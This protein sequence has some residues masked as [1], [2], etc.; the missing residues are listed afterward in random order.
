ML[1]LLTSY[2]SSKAWEPTRILETVLHTKSRGSLELRLGVLIVA[3]FV[4][5]SAVGLL[6]TQRQCRLVAD[7]EEDISSHMFRGYMNVP[8]LDHI[9]KNS[10]QLIRNTYTMPI[11]IANLA[12]LPL[13]Q[14]TQSIFIVTFLLIVILL[15]SPLVVGISVLYFGFGIISYIRFFTSK[16]QKASQSIVQVSGACFQNMQEGFGGMKA[17]RSGNAT[18][19]ITSIFQRRRQALSHLRYKVLLF[20]QLPQYYLQSVLIGGIVIFA[21]VV[22][23]VKPSDPTALIGVVLVAFIR[24]MPSLFLGLSAVG[25]VRSSQANIDELFAEMSNFARGME[26]SAKLRSDIDVLVRDETDPVGSAGSRNTRLAWLKTI[27][28]KNVSFSYPGTGMPAVD[29]VTL[30]I[31]KGEFVGIVGTSGAGKTTTVDMLLGLFQPTIGEIRID[32]HI[33]DAQSADRWRRSIGYVPQ[34]VF[35]LDGSVLENVAFG[36]D[37]EKFDVEA[38]RRAVRRAQLEGEIE[39]MPDGLNTRLGER[40]VRLSGGQKQR[41]GIARALYSD[42]EVLILDEATSSLDV[43][44]EAAVTETVEKLGMG[45]TRIVIAHRLSTVR[46]CDRLF[47]FEEGRLV[48]EGEF[49]VLKAENETFRRMAEL[50]SVE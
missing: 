2:S 37:G 43:Q 34:D 49:S 8:Y 30:S 7:I 20:A 38:V 3:V 48:A 5:S 16:V 44:T 25:K 35:L 24:L 19:V 39:A 41:I 36:L 50:A 31:K 32:N 10:A 22:G 14:L 26:S 28:L 6:L 21:I 11:D 12:V 1:R 18:N 42:P 27:D 47:F 15:A 46:L 40:G 45:L 4:V 17:F 29:G 13:L 33:L 9:A 23:L